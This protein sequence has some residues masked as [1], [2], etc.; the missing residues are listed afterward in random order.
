MVETPLHLVVVISQPD[1]PHSQEG[2][3]LKRKWLDAIAP[4]EVLDCR[5]TH[6][7]VQA[8]QIMPLQLHWDV[9]EHH[10]HGLVELA[11]AEY[12]A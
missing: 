9:P 11:P 7:V 10:L 8:R 3:L 4:R 6:G 2:T 1:H 5:V 12:G